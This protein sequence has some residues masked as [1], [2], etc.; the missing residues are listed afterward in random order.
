MS[1]AIHSVLDQFK[2]CTYNINHI[3][4]VWLSQVYKAASMDVIRREDTLLTAYVQS[5]ILI[6]ISYVL[7]SHFTHWIKMVKARSR[8][9]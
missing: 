7:C 2:L 8:V 4:I 5:F 1:Q 9:T 3:L 6:I